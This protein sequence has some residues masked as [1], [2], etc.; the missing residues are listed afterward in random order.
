MF[1]LHLGT[2]YPG[3]R[4]RY[5][6][7]RITKSYRKWLKIIQYLTKFKQSHKII[8]TYKPYITQNIK[9]C[10]WQNIWK[11]K[12]KIVNILNDHNNVKQIKH[13]KT[14]RLEGINQNIVF[15]M[16]ENCGFPFLKDFSFSKFLIMS[17]SF[18]SHNIKIKGANMWIFLKTSVTFSKN[19]TN[20]C[21]SCENP[22][23]GITSIRRNI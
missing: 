23:D 5:S 18:Y 12:N 10:L 22:N 3:L 4:E 11:E 8:I 2:C 13:R 6:N 15:V 14:K 9:K 1:H 21:N 17:M 19:F 20:T 16:W 7:Q